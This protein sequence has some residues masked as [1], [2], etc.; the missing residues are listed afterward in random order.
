M[1]EA[2]Q[3]RPANRREES[4][5]KSFIAND[6]ENAMDLPVRLA[7]TPSGH[8]TASPP[9]RLVE[10]EEIWEAQGPPPGCSPTKLG[11]NLGKSYCQLYDAT[12][13]DSRI[14]RLLPQ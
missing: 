7:V 11:W 9:V 3:Q 5:N 6:Q 4:M 1:C 8:R 13:N 10:G 2:R 12:V 14:S